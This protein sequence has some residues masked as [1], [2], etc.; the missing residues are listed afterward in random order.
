[1][2]EEAAK[3]E[4]SS[5][6]QLSEEDTSEE[7]ALVRQCILQ[8]GAAMKLLSP[9]SSR[10]FFL[11]AAMKRWNEDTNGFCEYWLNHSDCN[12]F[13]TMMFRNHCCQCFFFNCF[14]HLNH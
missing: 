11:R 2:T 5:T 12:F 14:S 13:S 1:M 9:A 4:N 6:A 8:K 3:L 10:S 7:A